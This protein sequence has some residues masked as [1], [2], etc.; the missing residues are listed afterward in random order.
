M[1]CLVGWLQKIY[2][3]VFEVV[4]VGAKA[5]IDVSSLNQL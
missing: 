3:S 2:E 5:N 1:Y 4:V